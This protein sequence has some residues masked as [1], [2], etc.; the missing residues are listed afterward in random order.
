MRTNTDAL[1][2]ALR[3]GEYSHELLLACVAEGRRQRAEYISAGLQRFKSRLAAWMRQD[4]QQTG[5]EE[6]RVVARSVTWEPS[7]APEFERHAA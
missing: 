4:H 6:P 7:R 2:E 1:H 3:R 5:A